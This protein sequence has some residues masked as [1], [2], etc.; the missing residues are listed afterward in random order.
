MRQASI[1]RDLDGNEI[2]LAHL[3]A[4]E[5]KLLTRLRRRAQANPDWDAFDNYWTRAVPA[6]YEARGLAR[7]AVPQTVLWR[8][9]G[10]LSARI[11]IA[12]GLAR[13][14]DYRD[15]LEELIRTKYPSRRAFCE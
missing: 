6:F 8:I 4:E 13:L 9:A 1:Y 5:R 12:A 11:A 7:K 10:D 15:D 2:C 3:D 14:G